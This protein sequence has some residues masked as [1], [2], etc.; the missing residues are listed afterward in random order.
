M[1]I[2]FFD[3][4][5]IEL[6]ASKDLLNNPEYYNLEKIEIPKIKK[7]IKSLEYIIAYLD[8]TSSNEPTIISNEVSTE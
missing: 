2:K 8:R 6:E 5:K 3:E 7:Y 4:A 1:S